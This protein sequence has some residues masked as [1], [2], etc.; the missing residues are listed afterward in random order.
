VR[1]KGLWGSGFGWASGEPH[2]GRALLKG[3]WGVLS[4]GI[5]FTPKR[6]VRIEFVE[7][8][9]FPRGADRTAINQYL[10]NFYNQEPE[11]NT[12][13]PYSIWQGRKPQVRPERIG[14]KIE[15]QTGTISATV[16]QAV[17]EY[18]R[19]LTGVSQ[20]KDSDELA[21]DL[22]L[23]SLARTD[24]V[25]WLEREFGLRQVDADVLRS[26][27]DVLLAAG[28]Q[29]VYAG[30][31]Q[32]KPV[33]RAWFK[34][35]GSGPLR[36]PQGESI[37][38][39]F[40]AQARR[41]P[42]KVVIADQTSGARTC[43]DI[44]TACLVLQE[45]LRALEGDYIGIMLPASV[46]ADVFYLAALFAGKTPV[47]VN[48]TTGSRNIIESLNRL[49]V[50]HILTARA[51]VSRLEMQGIELGPLTERFIFAEEIGRGVSK[52]EK[53]RAAVKARFNWSDLESAKIPPIAAVLFTSGSETLPKAVPLTHR[54]ILTN[55][56]DVISVIDA[57]EDNTMIGFL[58]PFHSFG[59]TANICT[60]LC[61]SLRTVYHA[62]P[63]DSA[64]LAR[65]IEAYKIDY[66]VGTPT[67][68]AGILRAAN[69]GELAGLRLAVTGAERASE[70]VYDGLRAKCPRATILE[71][72]GV[73]E[74]SPI[75]TLNDPKKPRPFT[76]GKL[77]PSLSYC[78]LDPET[79]EVRAKGDGE[80]T[81]VLCV[82]GP[83][84]FPGYLNYTGPSPFTEIDGRGFYCTGDF[85]TVDADGVF[86]FKGRLKRFVK[87]GGEMIS[88]PAIEAVLQKH[89]ASEKDEGPVFAVESTPGENPE[90]VLFTVCD[91]DRETINN[92]IRS[93]GLSGLHNIR[94]IVKLD[95]IPT[96][97]TGKTDYRA[98]KK[99][100]G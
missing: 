83:S 95:E 11:R 91:I 79:R 42:D 86:T 39:I 22:G 13:V 35:Y 18:L 8:A 74:C 3:F 29:F 81:G 34:K 64:M 52:W 100:L 97:G 16:R 88:L 32:I 10:E 23:D 96:L 53:L 43:R 28:G 57:R 61:G 77:L 21:R 84:V 51:L 25:L 44:V 41:H 15:G 31:A 59:L 24:L 71:G 55:L 69:Q 17:Y 89:L 85:V 6:E 93:A 92:F 98:L 1:T 72:Y 30:P 20:V 7:P 45:R 5:F 14:P 47:M 49:A 26:V 67:F 66:L 70:A 40:L 75:I 60:A 68:L 62:N 54:N 99:S 38:E 65:M 19:K 90:L 58:P 78:L 63:M 33:P 87:L 56:C 94:R 9:N 4:S 36:I 37:P 2:I 82:A 80:A 73:T 46:A 48:W 27:S 12:Y 50:R 76:I